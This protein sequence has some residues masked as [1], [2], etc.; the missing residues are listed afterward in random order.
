MVGDMGRAKG[1]GSVYRA[2]PAVWRAVLELPPG[3]DGERRRKYFQSK[4]R[5]EANRRLRKAVHALASGQTVTTREPTLSQW[6][7]AW[8]ARRDDLKPSTK[9]GY[10]ALARTWIAP[11][12]GR[13]KLSQVTPSHVRAMHEACLAEDKGTTAKRAHAVLSGALQAAAKE[14]LVSGNAARVAGPPRADTARRDTL[15][16]AQARALLASTAGDPVSAAR[17]WTALLT[18]MRRSERLGLTAEFLDLD[19]GVVTVAWGLHRL[20]WRHGCGGACDKRRGADCPAR[21]IPIPPD[22]EARQVEGALWLLRPKSRAGWR[23]VPLFG[24]LRDSLAHLV[25]T[26]GVGPLGLVFTDGRGHA[27]DPSA[28]TRGWAADLRRAGIP[29]VPLH[30]ARHATATLLFELGVP[31]ATRQAILG[32]SSATVT[33]GYT[34]VADAVAADAMARLGDLVAS[35]EGQG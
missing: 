34:H 19:R 7:D 4:T 23:Q 20:A 11:T 21:T 22:T 25:E 27:V 15:T 31:E 26:R 3:P 8:L 28:D 18:G 10:A 24:P 33:M 30:S 32:H 1:S 9:D 35:A 2:G 6:L 14:G 17:C 13:V 12:I 5:A 16:A 29:H